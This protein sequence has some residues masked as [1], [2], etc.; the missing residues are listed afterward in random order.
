MYLTDSAR[1]WLK[2]SEAWMYLKLGRPRG[3]FCWKFPGPV[4]APGNLW[5]LKNCRHKP[6]ETLW[7]YIRCFA[8]QCNELTNLTDA[9]VIIAFI[10]GVTN[11][12]LVY[13]IGRK[14]PRTIKELLGIAT[15]HALGEDTMGAIFDHHKQRLSTTKSLM[16]ETTR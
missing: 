12:T 8:R 9:N 6:N 16:E 1:A 5:D 14:S 2:K 4:R 11:K 13:K 10:S 3:I 15:S 7:D